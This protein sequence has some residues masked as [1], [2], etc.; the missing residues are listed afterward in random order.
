MNDQHKI[1]FKSAPRVIKRKAQITMLAALAAVFMA[2]CASTGGGSGGTS[3][4]VERAEARWD[5]VLGGD[6]ERAYQYY[7]P[8]Y[9]SSHTR[10]DFEV[11]MRLRKVQYRE[12]EY[13]EHA[14][15]GDRCD[16]KFNVKYRIAS[17]VPG[18]DKWEGNTIIDETWIRTGDE[19]WY[20]PEDS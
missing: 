6:F 9:R 2:G 3:A 17:P 11:T 1:Q 5:A 18:L 7:S 14:C 8:G 13:A 15:E 4:L 19:W 10:G 12:A 16:L 20:L